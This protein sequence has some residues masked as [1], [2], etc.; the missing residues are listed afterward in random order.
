[1][2]NERGGFESDLTVVRLDS[3]EFYLI[4]GTAQT[5]RDKD[6]ITRHISAGEHAELIDLTDEFSVIGVMGPNA[7]DLLT[8]LTD[9]DFSNT[10]FSF[11]TARTIRLGSAT[12]RALRIT[13]VGELGWELHVP[14]SQACALYDALM[15]AGRDLRVANAGHYAVNSLRLEKGCRAWGV[16]LSPDDTPLEAGL[17]FALA[18]NKSIPF[19][20]RDA[21]LKQKESGLKRRLVLF[22]LQ[23]PEAIL[24][25]S[26][27]I[28]RDGVAVGYTTSGAYGHGLGSAVALGYVGHDGGINAEFINNGRYEINIAG[29]R[30]PARAHFRTPYDPHRK[31]ILS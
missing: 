13:Y 27:P 5:L 21:L 6:W 14:T 26:E 10:A 19:L 25:G 20:G 4:S 16:D 22:T 2:L 12:V 17:E 3:D 8:R 7:R 29:K 31:R 1:M 11:A 9:A 24:W 30:Y 28:L 23:D 18:W 15:E